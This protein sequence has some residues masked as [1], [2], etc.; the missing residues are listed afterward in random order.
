MRPAQF[1]FSRLKP[2]DH[3]P[4][5]LFDWLGVDIAQF[6]LVLVNTGREAGW[7]RAEV[8]GVLE[9]MAWTGG[10]GERFAGLRVTSWR[11]GVGREALKSKHSTWIEAPAKLLIS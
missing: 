8:D 4:G 1:D 5:R 10:P 9:C 2:L 3:H 11:P 6:G 7:R